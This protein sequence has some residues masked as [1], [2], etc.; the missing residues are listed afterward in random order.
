MVVGAD[1]VRSL[2][3]PIGAVH[4]DENY[5]LDFGQ[6]QTP[7]LSRLQLRVFDAL[8]APG[9]EGVS[10]SVAAKRSGLGTVLCVQGLMEL[11]DRGL[12]ALIGGLWVRIEHERDG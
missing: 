11:K 9:V 2:L 5:M 8:N 4:A 6:D 1:D 3:A 12:A 10:T 7:K